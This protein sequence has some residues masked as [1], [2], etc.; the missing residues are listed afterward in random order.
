MTLDYGERVRVAEHLCETGEWPGDWLDANA[1]QLAALIDPTCHD[2]AYRMDRTRFHCSECGF[3][4]WVRHAEDG[5]DHFPEY[6]PHCG[7]RIA[8]LEYR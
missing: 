7:A 8:G 2:I 6:C 3:D 4:G 5:K 1:E